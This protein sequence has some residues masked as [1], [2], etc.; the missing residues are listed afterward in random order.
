MYHQVKE[1]LDKGETLAVATIV[2]TKGSTPREV[3]AKMVVTAWGE[4][5]GTIGGGCGEADVKRE[6]IEVIRTRKPRMVRVDLLDDIS[7][8]SPAVCG[9]IMNVFVDPW[10]KEKSGE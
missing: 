1:F 7:S 2:S 3:G 9:G 4:I 8:D 5:L 10:W 6:A